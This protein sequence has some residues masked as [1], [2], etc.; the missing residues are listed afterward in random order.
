MSVD[1]S[2]NHKLIDEMVI[3]KKRIWWIITIILSLGMLIPTIW[4]VF[5]PFN[6]NMWLIFSLSVLF[7][8]ATLMY[9]LIVLEI[10]KYQVFREKAIKYDK[11][12]TIKNIKIIMK[13]KGYNEVDIKERQLYLKKQ[14]HYKVTQV[15][16]N[17]LETK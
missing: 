11:K 10:F 2:A 6:K 17:L 7:L 9:R 8:V 4:A 3:T 13:E 16:I 1:S 14:P 5:Y 15:Y 12:K